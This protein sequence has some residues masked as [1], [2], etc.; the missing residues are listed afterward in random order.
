MTEDEPEVVEAMLR[1]FYKSRYDDLGFDDNPLLF[2]MKVHILAEKYF[3]DD[4]KLKAKEHFIES[5]DSND[6]DAL[7]WL[8]DAAKMAFAARNENCKSCKIFRGQI[9]ETVLFLKNDL[10]LGDI[11]EDFRNIVSDSPGFIME[12]AKALA[13]EAVINNRSARRRSSFRLRHL[14][15]SLDGTSDAA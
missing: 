8:G 4:L 6:K 9:L 5:F 13:A 1:F 11:R 15:Q 7:S 14:A 2:N 12:Y 3:V 10:L